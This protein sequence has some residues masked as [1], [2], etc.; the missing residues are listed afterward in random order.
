MLVIFRTRGEDWD[1][2][3][4]TLRDNEQV[5]RGMGCT[6]VEAYRNRK[7][8]AHVLDY[9][10]LLLGWSALLRSPAAPTLQSQFDH[11]LVD[12]YQDTNAQQADLDRN[13][14][15]YKE[16]HWKKKKYR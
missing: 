8:A 14:H 13:P 9:D 4:A 10:D 2:F 11:V 16:I 15:M 12:E 7:R 5:I 3:R 1:R 6:R